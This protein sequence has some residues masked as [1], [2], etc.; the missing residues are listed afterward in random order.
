MQIESTIRLSSNTYHSEITLN[1]L[2]P[3]EEEAINSFGA[4]T[5]ECGG[6]FGTTGTTGATG[7]NTYFELDANSR[8]FPTQFPVKY[9]FSL[10]DYPVGTTAPPNAATR[11][12]VW[13]DTIIERVTT[14]MQETR[15]YGASGVGTT[16]QVIDTT[17]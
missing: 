3:V 17:P 2:T 5:V 6:E 15:A 12:D 13:R 7:T 10:L 9:S 8:A 16:I 11:A 14:A 1:S 4:P